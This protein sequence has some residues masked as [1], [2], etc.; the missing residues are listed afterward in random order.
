M[1]GLIILK[2]GG[3]ICTGKSAGKFEVREDV[4][5][6]LARE[7]KEAQSKDGFRLLVVNG[8]GP[9][10]HVNVTEYGIN[11]GLESERDFEGYAKTVC[12]CTCLNQRVSELMRK[13]GLSAFPV[14]S[15]TVIVQDRKRIVHFDTSVLEELWKQD[16][17]AVPVM[18]GTM[19]PDR[20]LKGS[21]V[22]GDAVIE[23]AARRLGAKLIIFA[24]DV[25]GVF[26]ADPKKDKDA[27]LI[28]SITERNFDE[29]SHGISGSASTDVTGGMMNKVK[30]LLG[31]SA[32][33]L[34]MNGEEPGRLKDALLGKEVRGTVVR[35][36]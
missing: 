1:E 19:V 29:V 9:F 6:R 21:V 33:T 24:A 12:D 5:K 25:D 34:I 32:P 26:T 18:N 3:S 13:E 31:F 10:G 4:V 14:P 17:E 30:K 2:I 16:E 20:A 36:G 35:K 7:I 23:G 28:E 27:K 11:D 22:S 15:S 8:A